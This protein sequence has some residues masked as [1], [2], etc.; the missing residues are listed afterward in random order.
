M[1]SGAAD[2][3]SIRTGDRRRS[4]RPEVQATRLRILR[5]A[6]RLYA[7]H[8]FGGVSLREIAIAASQGNNN[9]VQYHF[10]SRERLI[11]AIFLA[12]T[13][14]MDPARQRMLDEAE[15]AGRLKD[16]ASLL[17]IISM[18]HLSQCD[19]QGH[20]P[21]A[22]F[23][24]HY[25]MRRIDHRRDS[26]IHHAVQAAPAFSRLCTLMRAS[27]VHLSD[28]IV[29]TRVLLCA[30]MFINMLIRHDGIHPE[31]GDPDWLARHASDTI[32]AMTIALCRPAQPDCLPA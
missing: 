25:L 9:A 11:D 10:G 12:R 28:D 5:A 3:L 31:K 23:M 26:G 15:A 18:P 2:R 30:L 32:D 24:M 6:E 13:V 8:G 16:P 14:E 20:H 21:H 29:A 17:A 19:E 4:E 7:D 1:E 27:V 22:G